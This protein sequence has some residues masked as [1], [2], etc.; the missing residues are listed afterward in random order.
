MLLR[1]K[2]DLQ[3]I[4]IIFLTD[5]YEQRDDTVYMVIFASWN[6]RPSTLANSFAP[7]WISKGTV[8]FFPVYNNDF[9]EYY[10]ETV[11]RPVIISYLFN[12]LST[13]VKKIFWFTMDVFLFCS[14]FFS[15]KLCIMEKNR[16]VFFPEKID[17]N[18]TGNNSW[19]KTN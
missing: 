10:K 7:Y 11:D 17:W 4:L 5:L 9:K 12:H 13:K 3:Y 18:I 15:F 14:R 8:A 1:I 6:L 16:Y 2:F 19:N